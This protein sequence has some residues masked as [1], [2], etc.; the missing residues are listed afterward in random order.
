M[1]VFKKNPI[2]SLLVA[3]SPVLFTGIIVMG[4]VIGFGTARD[5][6]A[7]EGMRLLQES[8]TRVAIHSYSVNGHFPE[9]LDYIVTNYNIF[10]DRTRFV[11]FYEV[12][13]S[14]ILPDIR[15]FELR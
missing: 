1:R 15:V 13:A 8:L 6:A 14:N 11:V 9:S 7:A 5:E 2:H 12:F 10:I 4:M 3:L